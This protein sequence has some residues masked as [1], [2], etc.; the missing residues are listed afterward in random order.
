MLAAL[1]AGTLV[2]QISVI[3]C[4][5]YDLD[6]VAAVGEA[7]KAWINGTVGSAI[8]QLRGEPRNWLLK[9]LGHTWL[10]DTTAGRSWLLD[11]PIG[12]RFAQLTKRQ[13]KRRWAIDITSSLALNARANRKRKAVAHL[14][15]PRPFK[16]TRTGTHEI[17][18]EG[19][20]HRPPPKAVAV[21]RP[22]RTTRHEQAVFDSVRTYSHK[23]RS[24]RLLRRPLQTDEAGSRSDFEMS[25]HISSGLD[26]DSDYDP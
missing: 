4:I 10:R 6:I 20:S 19:E 11:D 2:M 16:L 5:G 23:P 9:D 18:D 1:S 7:Q 12:R 3:K 21:S 25:L 26:S 24:F 17:K 15:P 13:A 8:R 22:R 14:R